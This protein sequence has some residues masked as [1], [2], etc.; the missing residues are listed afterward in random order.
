MI[1]IVLFSHAMNAFDGWETEAPDGFWGILALIIR[2]GTPTFFVIFGVAI[3]LVHVQRWQAGGGKQVRRALTKRAAQCYL[4]FALVAVAAVIGGELPIA[5]L[6][7]G[8]LL[9]REVPNGTVLSFYAFACLACLVLVPLRLKIGAV[10]VLIVCIAWW[11]IEAMI[12]ATVDSSGS[13]FLPRVL[14]IGEGAGPSMFHGLALVA[15]GM[16]IGQVVRAMLNSRLS[17]RQLAPAAAVVGVAVVGAAIVL[18]QFGLAETV[19]RWLDISEFRQ[20]NHW[21]Y[22]V[23]GFVAAV[24]VLAITYLVVERFGITRN[25][26]PGPFGSSSLLAFGGGNVAL[27]LIIGLG[28]VAP[29]APIALAVSCAFVGAVW[30]TVKVG[31]IVKA[32][33]RERQL[34][35]SQ[36]V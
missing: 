3:E 2:V 14:G 1:A 11:P 8:L 16:V 17:I 23:L 15:G 31:R 36:T 26:P 9:L 27:N 24:L 34:V 12:D 7:P 5:E 18:V 21:A 33:R 6:V 13:Y 29:N 28:F 10:G 20:T 4:A 25:R 32:R 30:V 35:G 22:F 19:R